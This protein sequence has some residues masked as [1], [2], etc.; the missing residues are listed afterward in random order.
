MMHVQKN[1]KLWSDSIRT[2]VVLQDAMELWLVWDCI[3][4]I[5]TLEYSWVFSL[6]TETVSVFYFYTLLC[7]LLNSVT[8]LPRALKVR[9]FTFENEDRCDIPL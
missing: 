4:H 9:F 7:V 1:I 2:T 3:A 5:G 8:I 6:C